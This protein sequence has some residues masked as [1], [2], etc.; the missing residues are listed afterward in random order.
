MSNWRAIAPIW[1]YRD[2]HGAIGE[3][4]ELADGVCVLPTPEY[5]RSEQATQYLAAMMRDR[6]AH[7]S[8]YSLSL[9][10]EASRHDEPDPD[11]RG[12]GETTRQ[13]TAQMKLELGSLAMWIARPARVGIEVV[14]HTSRTDELAPGQISHPDYLRPLPRDVGDHL[15]IRDIEVARR[16]LGVTLD[17][18]RQ[19][20]ARTS[21]AWS[22]IRFLLKGLQEDS[23]EMR[24]VML[25]IAMEAL[26][27]S[28]HATGEIRFRSSQRAAFFV[29]DTL[30][31]ARELF[32]TAMVSYQ[33]RSRVV[34]GAR[35]KK[36]DA[37]KA[38]EVLGDT[39]NLV[40]R[41]LAKVLLDPEL[42]ETFTSGRRDEYLDELVFRPR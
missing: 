37:A 3:G 41:G 18:E 7:E 26:F 29:A 12:P 20:V 30:E 16:L 24:L 36:L 27:G 14:F 39:E 10:Y 1:S 19:D 25:W 21:T 6:V 35:L 23:K 15:N 33:W 9:E 32:K 42:V 8:P 40:R 17:I 28:E 38:D 5:I 13:G 31:E 11:W 4:V 22:A 2:A 34:H